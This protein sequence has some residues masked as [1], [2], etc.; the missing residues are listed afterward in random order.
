M[1]MPAVARRLGVSHSTLYRYVHDRD[2]LVLAALDLAVREFEWPR[3]DLGWRDLLLAFADALWRFTEGN[4]GMAEAIQNTP[5]LPAR[6]T[7]LATAYIAR[8]RA[9]GFGAE[10]A[11]VAFDFVAD[12]TVATEIAM[13]GLGHVFDTPHGRR[14]LR[15]LYHESWGAL[16]GD[17]ESVL[18]GRGW[19][20]AKLAI[21]LDGLALRIGTRTPEPRAELVALALA[22]Y[23]ELPADPSPGLPVNDRVFAAFRAAGVPE[24]EVAFAANLLWDH[25]FGAARAPRDR[26]RKGIELVVDGLLRGL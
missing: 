25:V 1:S 23:E 2:D 14:S 6:V 24:E 15:E 3:V 9:D 4:P 26:A 11:A 13:R 17:D 7:E 19:L 8:L 5:G 16:F 21:L 18:H 12:L 22:G 20:D 10:D